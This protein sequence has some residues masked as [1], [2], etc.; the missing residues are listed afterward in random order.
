MFLSPWLVSQ[1]AAWWSELSTPHML[2]MPGSF[3]EWSAQRSSSENDQ[4]D[5]NSKLE[6]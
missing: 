5:L 1:A 4:T 6:E 3:S 2:H